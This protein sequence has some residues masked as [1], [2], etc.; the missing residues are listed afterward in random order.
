MDFS[1]AFDSLPHILIAK[2]HAYGFEMSSLKLIYS[3]LTDRTQTV[4][5]KG[6]CSTEHQIKSGVPQGSLL[7]VLLFNM[8][9][10]DM[11]DFIDDD[12]HNFADDNNLSSVGHTTEEAKALLINETEAALNWIEANEKIANPEKF[13]L[14]F[15]SPNKQDLINQQS[16]D[17]KGIFLK[18][19]TKFTLLGVDIDNR[20][21]FHSHTNN[22]CRKAVNQIN[23]FKRLSVH[24]GKNEKMV[25]MKSFILSNFNY[26]PLVWHFCG[27][28]DTDRMERI[29]KRALRMVLDDYESDYE[30]LLQKVNMSTLQIV[31]IKTLATEI[32]K[33]FHSL[34]PI[35][36]NE[37]FQTNPSI[38][39]NLRSKNNLVTLR[40]NSVTYGKNSLRILGPTI[41]N[42][43][44][45]EYKTAEDLQT[46]KSLLKQWNR[47]QCICN[48]CKYAP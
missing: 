41:W 19:E 3:Y 14:M 34:N 25:L 33:T 28:T 18:S 29:Q 45:D 27:K 15:L 26:C 13:H 43:L 30:T 23:A 6:E 5:V 12:L 9:L 36:M 47:P 10:N 7:G 46:F 39:R 21:T 20:L 1:K 11:F 44:P 31:K 38:T 40:Y 22:I 42:H 35:Y 16:I 8:Y 4:K 48:L 24:M 32:F 17:I 2:I 37:I